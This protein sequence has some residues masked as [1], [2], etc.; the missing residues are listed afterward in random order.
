MI[1]KIKQKLTELYARRH[2]LRDIRV[3]GLSLFLVIV[4]LIS[5]SG[6]KAIQ[7][8]YTLQKQIAQL[9]QENKLQQLK[10]E[11]LNLENE[12][13]NTNQYLELSAR[14]NFGLG[15]S[16]ETELL[17]PKNV[18]LAQINPIPNLMPGS[19][20][21]NVPQTGYEKNLHAWIDFFLHRQDTGN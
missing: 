7:T 14:Q 6:V 8:N 9:T 17:V 3:L 16:G 10:N 15:D 21:L 5:W 2:Q 12:Y 11:D 4:L 18:A 13:Y 19:G 1:T 20:S